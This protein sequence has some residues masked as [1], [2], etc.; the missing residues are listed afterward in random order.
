M[1]ISI[2]EAKKMLEEG[3]N[4]AL[5]TETVYG[6][7]AR[8]HDKKA[9]ETIFSLKGRPRDNPLIVHVA[10]VSDI[11][12]FVKTLPPVV[13]LL[14]KKFWPG[15][16]TLVLP[17]IE[18]TIPAI[19]RA[20]LPTC[21]FRIPN[22]PLTQEL[23]SL[24]G[25]L[26]MPS[27]NLSGRPSSTQV[28]HV[29]TDF[30]AHFP[31][32]DG[33]PCERG[34]ESTILLVEEKVTILRQGMITANDLFSI[35]G[36]LPPIA[37][38]GEKVLCPGQLFQHYAPKAKLKLSQIFPAGS[39]VVGHSNRTYPGCTLFS[40]GNTPEQM[41]QNFYFTLRKLDE[42]G[43]K[44]AFVDSDFPDHPLLHTLKERLMK[45]AGVQ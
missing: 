43:V 10:K 22:H 26:V 33:G 20:S 41:A 13:H 9:I 1:K 37:E 18:Q 27:A 15:P 45:A 34:L 42:E 17:V 32:V 8:Y 6:L 44:E 19:V 29:E 39:S 25:P 16:L 23:L 38:K 5:P 14:A 31:V 2:L 3:K 21:A 30:G 24:T 7:A 28:C 35:L 4:V 11:I 12:P 40:L 36:Y